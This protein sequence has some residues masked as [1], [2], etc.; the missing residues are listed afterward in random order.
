MI[1][2]DS[3]KLEPGYSDKDLSDSILRR[4]RIAN[5]QLHSF[6]IVKRSIDA[7]D[8]NDIKYILSVYA[9]VDDEK[10]ILEDKRIKNVCAAEPV[11]YK[12]PVRGGKAFYK[13]V[14]I[15]FGPAGMI[16][17]YKLARAGLKPIVLE[18]GRDVDSRI[19]IVNDFWDNGSLDT[20]TNVQFG[21]GGA[22]T[23]SDGKLS[24]LIHD[25][26]GRIHE[27]FR[28]LVEN[29]ADESILYESKPHVGTDRLAVI[30]KNIRNRICEWEGEV[31]F[32]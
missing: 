25:K 13:P 24:T 21:E 22:G 31:S 15:G 10:R 11:S 23:F 9:E 30:V 29:G 16:C 4:L 18:R 5:G 27:F 17:A 14:I 26:A 8:K 12:E 32:G 3:I 1:R 6:R 2:I 28:I 7:R 20:S 19:K